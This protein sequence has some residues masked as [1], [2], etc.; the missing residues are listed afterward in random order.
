MIYVAL[1]IHDERHT[2]GVL[3]W[4]LRELFAELG[5]DFRILAVDDASTDGTADVLAPYQ[6]VLP[7][8][9]LRNETRQ[10]YAASLE[11]A[12]RLAVKTSQYPKRD[13]LL[14]MQSDFTDDPGSVAEMLRCFQGGADLVAGARADFRTA[15]RSVRATRLGARLMARSAAVP[16]GISD[17]WCGFRMYRLIVLRR[18]LAS[19]DDGE[20]L[21][22]YD[23]WAGNLE[24]LLKVS[25]FLRQWDEVDV[26]L[27]LSR[28]YRE[29][30]FRALPEL[31]S[32]LRARREATGARPARESA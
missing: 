32:L 14:V 29:S 22:R 2:A 10:G 13:P 3:M 15:P 24:L 5:R 27:D 23:G 26:P 12:I 9:I 4:R 25:P 11:Q 8:T 17:P 19:L 1:P 18:A 21:M 16:D 20:P 30:R 6:R 31:R 28:R 7:L